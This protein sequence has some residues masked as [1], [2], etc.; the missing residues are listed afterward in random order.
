MSK[1]LKGKNGKVVGTMEYFDKLNESCV[2]GEM[3]KKYNFNY[4][5]S[6]KDISKK[7]EK[8]FDEVY[9]DLSNNEKYLSYIDKSDKRNTNEILE[10]IADLCKIVGGSISVA[11]KCISLLSKNDKAK[12]GASDSDLTKSAKFVLSNK[13]FNK[14]DSIRILEDCIK[15]G[16]NR[17][18]K[19]NSN[20]EKFMK[21]IIKSSRSGYLEDVLIKANYLDSGKKITGKCGKVLC[22]KEYNNHVANAV[23]GGVGARGS[24]KYG[25]SIR[26]G[27]R[28]VATK[29]NDDLD[30]GN[31]DKDY[32]QDKNA[33]NLIKF[34]EDVAKCGE[35]SY[36]LKEKITKLAW[37]VGGD[38]KKILQLQKNLNAMGI[39]CDTGKL[40]EDGVYGKETKVA[41]DN[42]YNTLTRGATP[43]LSWVDPLKSDMTGIQVKQMPRRGQ[44]VPGGE[45]MIDTLWDYS[46]RSAKPTGV[47]VF[48]ADVPHGPYEN[49]HINTLDK[50][51]IKKGNYA[52]TNLQMKV[53]SFTNH[54][55][56]DDKTFNV[57]KNLIMCQSLSELVEESY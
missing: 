53:D 4:Y 29:L 31:S 1:E 7:S 52:P 23:T 35:N 50:A 16:V 48:R 5:D 21:E 33:Y 17:A 3:I 41:W 6:I 49:M 38:P 46:L 56:I 40:L 15:N 30:K 12:S 11:D 36:N 37:F 34:I 44:N 54:K 27:L 42:F 32:I 24:V 19:G 26:N 2:L 57:L 14:K 22:S 25:K 28:F 20:K 39:K 9:S 8:M 13:Y 18:T 45:M 10:G 43:S 47:P 55:S 51:A